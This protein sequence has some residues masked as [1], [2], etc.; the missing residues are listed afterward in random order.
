M[1]AEN[2]LSALRAGRQQ[3]GDPGG[4]PAGASCVMAESGEVTLLDAAQRRRY[5]LQPLPATSAPAADE[6]T[7]SLGVSP[8][9]PAPSAVIP[10]AEAFVERPVAGLHLKGTLDYSPE[11]AEALRREYETARARAGLSSSQ[12]VQLPTFDSARS[13]PPRA[14]PSRPSLRAVTARP[15]SAPPPSALPPPSAVL[16]HVTS[17]PAK[18]RSASGSVYGLRGDG[19]EL[20]SA[21]DLDPTAQSPLTYRERAYVLSGK[22]DRIRLEVLLQAEL[23]CIRRELAGRARGQF[24][25]LGVFHDAFQGTPERPPLATLEWKD[26]RGRAVFQ[27]ID[28]SGPS[29]S[30]EAPDQAASSWSS[31]AEGP[32][33]PTSWPPISGELAAHPSAPASPRDEAPAPPPRPSGLSQATL[34]NAPVADRPPAS[35][36]PASDPLSHE[37]PP[38]AHEAA[39]GAVDYVASAAKS[40]RASW[41]MHH[42]G[43]DARPSEPD[44]RLASVFESMSDLYLLGTPLSGLEFAIELLSRFI[45]SDAVSACL[46]DINTDEFRFVALSGLGALDRKAS[47]IPSTAGLFGVARRMRDD[48]L[49]VADVRAESRYLP[50]IDGRTAIAADSLLYAP[51]RHGGQ[52]LGMLQLIN[53]ADA[54]GFSEADVA[55]LTYVASQLG[56][57]LA[58]C[59]ALSE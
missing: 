42:D 49:L 52:L 19:L 50:T 29:P 56:E 5:V 31:D 32:P 23:A 39:S 30:A 14:A 24:V 41:P 10:T 55:V 35:E 8:T 6:A 18:T 57:F 21:R 20:L 38:A 47:A 1:R 16:R 33:Q 54:G 48:V 3:L 45:P 43:S 9:L 12:D 13:E 28:E 27:L 17:D 37:P 26:W 22:A 46:Y 34:V 40:A 58:H 59:R 36:S 2:W 25:R 15:S 4:V 44:N 7:S 11:R 51:V 53:R